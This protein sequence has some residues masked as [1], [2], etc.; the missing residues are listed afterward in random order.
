M[1]IRKENI[2]TTDRP[3]ELIG[4]IALDQ[5]T[6]GSL[7]GEFIETK[8]GHKQGVTAIKGHSFPSGANSGLILKFLF[9][10]GS[11]G[12]VEVSF[13]DFFKLFTAIDVKIW[14]KTQTETNPV[15]W[16]KFEEEKE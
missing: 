8:F 15:D 12:E 6:A 14:H 4:T 7:L 11:I 3:G 2:A 1:I 13:E 10:D 5:I 9:R 16:D